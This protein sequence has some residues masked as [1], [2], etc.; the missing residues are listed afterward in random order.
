MARIYLFLVFCITFVLGVLTSCT[1]TQRLARFTKRHPQLFRADTTI[2]QVDYYLQGSSTD[3]TINIYNYLDT[4][5]IINGRT[6]QTIIKKDSFIYAQCE[7]L[8]D[9]L[10]VPQKTIHHG[11]KE[12]KWYEGVTSSRNFTFLMLA[13]LVILL[14]KIYFERWEK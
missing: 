2:K 13:L 8:P 12:K 11:I 14:V 5:I 3:T 6:R 10:T 9:T 4:T 7:T 1:P